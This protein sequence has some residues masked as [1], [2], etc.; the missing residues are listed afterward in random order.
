[1]TPQ[2]YA[3]IDGL[4]AIAALGVMVEHMFGDLLRQT[5]PAAGPMNAA[6]DLLVQN[7]SLGRFG[8][9]LFFLI[10]GFVVPFSIGGERPLFQF[11]VSRAFRLYPALW[12]ALAVLASMAW[13][14]GEPPRAA[15]VLANMTMAPALFGQPW[16]SPIYWTL[17]VELAFYVL[18][19][20]LFSVGALRRV[21]VLSI[22]SLAL[23]IATALPVQLRIHGI[24]NLP[25]QYLGMHLSFL[26]LGLLLRLWLV[27]RVPGASVA[28]LAL[29]L[30]QI[31]AVPSVAA[32]SL[33]RGDNFIMEGLT[34]VLAAYAL[35]LVVFLAAVRFDRPRSL[36][37]SRTGLISYSM[38]LL[39]W[40]V[41]V[42]VYRFL[43]LTG[44]IGDSATMLV[45]A[46]LTLLVSWLVYRLVE[47]PMIMF[48]RAI[49]FRHG[50]A[51]RP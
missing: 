28:A 20:L 45:C 12:L 50:V 21:G 26:F 37:L 29:I 10:S 17:F 46:G 18:I 7:V 8:V 25:V 14:A 51:S 23:A 31:V 24:A 43:P 2:R 33:A 1:M 41:N 36:L 5:P 44:Q 4:R 47:R 6:G 16:L 11:A 35:A 49:V 9:A 34:P 38:Y 30:A 48:G 27:E 15:T 32:F 42:T 3:K 22:L 40:P 39:H 13:L 19:A